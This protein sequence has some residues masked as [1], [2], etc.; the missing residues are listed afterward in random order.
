MFHTSYKYDEDD[1]QIYATSAYSGSDPD[2]DDTEQF[3]ENI[4]H[5]VK[6]GSMVDIEY[7]PSDATN[8][9]LITVHKS[10]D[11]VFDGTEN[12][13]KSFTIENDGGPHVEPYTIPDTWAAGVYRLGMKSSG[14]TTTFGLRIRFRSWRKTKGVA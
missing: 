4:D 2:I 9:L 12:P 6:T 5:T 11:G 13:W 3:S 7:T 10:R 1:S 8:N 14:P